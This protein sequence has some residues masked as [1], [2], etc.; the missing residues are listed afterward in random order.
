HRFVFVPDGDQGLSVTWF[1]GRRKRKREV[2]QRRRGKGDNVF[3][4]HKAL[5]VAFVVL[6]EKLFL[7]LDSNWEFT[8][9]GRHFLPPR[10]GG[11]LRRE[12]RRGERNRGRL[13][14]L[15]FWAKFL[16]GASDDI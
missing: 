10:I 16:C 9:D 11:P 7:Q 6:D 4:A 12:W 1:P 5:D 14:D 13:V 15:V 8:D 3:Y 2:V